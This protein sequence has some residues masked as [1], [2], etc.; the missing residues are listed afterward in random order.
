M[1]VGHSS[2]TVAA[3]GGDYGQWLVQ[4]VLQKKSMDGQSQAVAELLRAMPSP[5]SH[6]GKS[7]DIRV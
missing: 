4:L 6:L 3:Q 2:G 5:E 7:I 1:T